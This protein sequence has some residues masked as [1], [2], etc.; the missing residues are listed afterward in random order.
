MQILHRRLLRR[1]DCT[2]RAHELHPREFRSLLGGALR[3]GSQT[4]RGPIGV[5]QHRATRSRP[6][7]HALHYLHNF[8]AQLQLK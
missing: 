7:R 3:L 4:P 5:H 1:A 6:P 2:N 8:A